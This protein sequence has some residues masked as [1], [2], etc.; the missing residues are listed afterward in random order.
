[1]HLQMECCMT[2]LIYSWHSSLYRPPTLKSWFTCR[3]LCHMY[4]DLAHVHIVFT[5][6]LAQMQDTG[7]VNVYH[8]NIPYLLAIDAKKRT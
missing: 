1:M 2:T 5:H 7:A 8:L 4:L 3:T 6:C